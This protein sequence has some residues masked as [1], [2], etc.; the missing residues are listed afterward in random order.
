MTKTTGLAGTAVNI[1]AMVYGNLNDK[2]LS[3]VCFTRSP[4]TGDA[5]IYGEWLQSSQGENVVAGIR[6][7]VRI[8]EMTKFGFGDALE[9]LKKTATSS[10][11][12]TRT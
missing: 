12:P 11:R 5:T 9:E 3:G 10:R 8:E 6:T 4:A 2:S 1:Q 7:P